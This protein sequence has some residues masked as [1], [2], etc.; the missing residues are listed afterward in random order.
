MAGGGKSKSKVQGSKSS[1]GDAGSKLEAL[2]QKQAVLQARV[3]Q[4]EA[5]EKVRE[6]KRDL[7]R[8]VLLGAYVLEEAAKAGEGRV[9]ELYQSLDGFLTRNSDRAL[10][11]L[12]A[13]EGEAGKTGSK[14]GSELEGKE[15]LV[16]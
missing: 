13:L 12:P 10:F 8:K 16:N 7:R 11:G 1:K 14:A 6:Q 15:G 9:A 3:E 2:K 5:R 4:L